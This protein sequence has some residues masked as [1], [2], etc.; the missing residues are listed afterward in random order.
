MENLPHPS[1]FAAAAPLAIPDSGLLLMF[2]SD[3]YAPLSVVHGTEHGAQVLYVKC[4]LIR[5]TR[6]PTG[7]ARYMP[8]IT[9]TSPL[10]SHP[11]FF[12]PFFPFFAEPAARQA[13]PISLGPPS[14]H[15]AAACKVSLTLLFAHPAVK[16]YL[17]H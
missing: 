17:P 9:E 16:L 5:A 2:R 6:S 7:I 4:S 12:F 3:A 14:N 15:A 8:W 13:A 1:P 11:I 10:T